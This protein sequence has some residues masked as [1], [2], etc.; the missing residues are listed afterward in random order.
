MLLEEY[1]EAI[2]KGLQTP[3]SQSQIARIVS[4]STGLSISQ[5]TVSR[6]NQM[7]MSHEARLERDEHQVHHLLLPWQENECGGLIFY[8]ALH[9]KFIDSSILQTHIYSPSYISDLVKKLHISFQ[10][11]RMA[12]ESETN[13]QTLFDI[14]Q[15]ERVHYLLN[16]SGVQPKQI[17]TVDK[18]FVKDKPS[19]LLG[20]GPKGLYIFLNFSF[21]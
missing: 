19:A 12:Y 4:K 9:H 13:T 6:Y 1:N 2:D 18:I 5:H 17:Y 11:A 21:Y 7:D 15:V 14:K 20:L 8:G 3:Y 16:V 10:R